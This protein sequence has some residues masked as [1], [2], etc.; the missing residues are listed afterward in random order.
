MHSR[1]QNGANQNVLATLSAL[2]FPQ[3]EI[4]ANYAALQIGRT[5]R[6][7]KPPSARALYSGVM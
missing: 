3:Q 1:K 2:K 4:E 7:E 5:S 6:A